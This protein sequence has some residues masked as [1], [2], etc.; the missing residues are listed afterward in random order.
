MGEEAHAEEMEY[1]GVKVDLFDEKPRQLLMRSVALTLEHVGFNGASAEAIEAI[2]S[3]A[4]TCRNS[5]LLLIFAYA[6]YL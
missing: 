3:E 1:G 5:G 2:C 4:E 6:K